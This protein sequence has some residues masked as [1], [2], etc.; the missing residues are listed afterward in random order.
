MSQKKTSITP[1]CGV[2][3]A[4]RATGSSKLLPGSAV[5]GIR[6]WYSGR[7]NV[8]ALSLTSMMVILRLI[9]CN[10]SRSTVCFDASH[11]ENH[12]KTR[13]RKSSRDNM[14]YFVRAV[15]VATKDTPLFKFIW[16]LTIGSLTL[17]PT[18]I[19][20]WPW[21]LFL[22]HHVMKPHR[23]WHRSHLCV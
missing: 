6:R 1:Y 5:S 19:V 4:S 9:T 11:Y 3:S 10:S 18:I 20:T 12:A 21:S 13:V 23:H 7:S 14:G 22:S 8:G 2:G 15:K 16:C 17:T